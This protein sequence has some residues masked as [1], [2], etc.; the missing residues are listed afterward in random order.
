MKGITRETID[1]ITTVVI[2][3]I[4]I[5]MLTVI[6]VFGNSDA[7]QELQGG[8]IQHAIDTGQFK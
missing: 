3:V 1:N 6:L 4:T 2:C 8:D 7:Q 5:V